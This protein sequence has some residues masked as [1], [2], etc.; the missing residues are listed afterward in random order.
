MSDGSVVELSALLVDVFKGGMF[1]LQLGR[2]MKPE[3]HVARSGCVAD[4]IQKEKL[5]FYG[6]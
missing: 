4:Y 1:S 3:A 6:E 2:L 5:S